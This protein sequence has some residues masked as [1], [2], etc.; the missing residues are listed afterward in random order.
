MPVSKR[1]YQV[2]TNVTDTFVYVQRSRPLTPASSRSSLERYIFTV[3]AK[4]DGLVAVATPGWPAGM[5]GYSTVSWIVSVPP[6]TEARLV[7]ANLTQPKCRNYHTDVSVQRVGRPLPDYSRREDEQAAREL[8]V[9]ESF[10][11]N[12]SNCQIDR[13]RFGVLAKITLQA[14]K[15]KSKSTW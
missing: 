14:P 9:S 2:C 6:N 12:M 8:T 4:R 11:L 15:E 10:Y 3:A 7:F 5:D 13:G 1:K